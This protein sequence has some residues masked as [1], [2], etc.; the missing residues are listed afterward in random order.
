[1][2]DAY[3]RQF[4]YKYARYE[5]TNDVVLVTEE[6]FKSHGNIKNQI[7]TRRSRLE[8]TL[9]NKISIINF[10]L[11]SEIRHSD[12]SLYISQRNERN[13]LCFETLNDTISPIDT[14]RGINIFLL[15]TSSID[16]D[17][18]TTPSFSFFLYFFP[19]FLF[20]ATILI[21]SVA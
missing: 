16:T 17:I 5:G 19:C 6:K 8:N 12:Q 11:S 14:I 21:S 1:M 7:K 4:V 2:V 15:L 9:T 13:F 3:D 10:I 20:T 18:D